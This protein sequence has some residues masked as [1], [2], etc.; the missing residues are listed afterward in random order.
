MPERMHQSELCV[1]VLSSILALSGCGAKLAQRAPIL[2][3]NR[4]VA[5]NAGLE[6]AASPSLPEDRGSTKIPVH[7][8]STTDEL[9]TRDR[10]VVLAFTHQRPNGNR[11]ASGRGAVPW[12]PFIDIPLAASPRWVVAAPDGQSSIWVVL[13]E[14]GTVQAFR[15]TDRQPEQ[16]EIA[17]KNL[18][19]GMPPLLLV[20][21]GDP[22]LVTVPSASASPLTHPTVLFR[23]GRLAFVATNG[24]L[25]LCDGGD[26]ARL[27]LNAPADGRLLVDERDRLLV[28][29]HATGRYGHGVLGDDI[30]AAGVS[31]VET[32]PELRLAHTILIPEP[33]VIEGT[34]AIWTDITGDGER[35]IIVTISGE[36]DG[37]QVAV[38]SENGQRLAAGPAI[39]RGFRWRHQLAVAPFGPSGEMELAV[40]RTPHIGG[41]VD[42][43]RLMG[44]RLE[45]VAQIS[46]FTSHVLGSRN[47]DMAA[48][49]DFD[50]D[51][52][53]DLL[54][55]DQARTHLARICRTAEGAGVAWA[56]PV[57]G[58]VSTNVS[59]VS[60]DRGRLAVGV[61]RTGDSAL[62]LWIP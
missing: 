14:D 27:A 5:V 29:S 58:M 62:R 35:E 11:L 10:R 53:V 32:M 21:D 31:L 8:A 52:R 44:E 7:E 2:Q 15:L 39:G 43:Y 57:G 61:G 42:F 3:T 36:E 50:G 25:V 37:A 45:I 23:S 56:V 1:L 22:V 20:K 28:L 47:L 19:A 60:L 13:L 48:A 26:C 55:P 12:V 59:T 54:L 49:G 9:E 18:P 51:G 38:Y 33:R 46:A 17:P 24:D 41:V 4:T 30:E 6:R 40:V 34:S 16:I